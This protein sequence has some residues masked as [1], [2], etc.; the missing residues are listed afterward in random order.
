MMQKT[1]TLEKMLTISDI[2]MHLQISKKKASKIM[3][4]PDFPSIQIGKRYYVMEQDYIAWLNKYKNGKIS[5][6]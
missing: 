5:L 3:H 6:K 2:E 1:T 4:M